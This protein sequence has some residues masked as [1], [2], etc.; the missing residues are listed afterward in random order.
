MRTAFIVD[1]REP[2]CLEVEFVRASGRTEALVTLKVSDVREV[3]DE[4]L[5]AVRSLTR[6]TA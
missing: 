4:D 6:G 5:V 1:L 3:R 2:D